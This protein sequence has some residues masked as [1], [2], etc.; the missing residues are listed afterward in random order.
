MGLPIE[1]K[2]SA[3]PTAGDAVQR[4]VPTCFLNERVS[5]VSRRVET[6]GGDMAVVVDG[7]GVVLGRL[8]QKSFAQHPEV[9]VEDV[10]EDGPTTIRPDTKL[11][12]I[13]PRMQAKNVNH[14]IVT[15]ANGRLTGILSRADGETLLAYQTNQQQE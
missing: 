14:I 5:V 2:N 9:I 6:A 11:A 3:Y 1:G 15:T 13:I 10:M 12:D 7:N 8:R 4:N